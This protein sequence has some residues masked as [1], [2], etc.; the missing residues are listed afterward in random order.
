MKGWIVCLMTQ[1]VCRDTVRLRLN[2]AGECRAG[3]GCGGLLYEF[4]L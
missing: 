4:V 2:P 3:T 1:R